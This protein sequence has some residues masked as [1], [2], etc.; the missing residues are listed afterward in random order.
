M[1]E[2]VRE[3]GPSA[4]ERGATVGRYTILAPLGMG[5]VGEVFAAYDPE[6]DRKVALKLLRAHGD[7]NDVRGQARLLREA[8]AMARLAHP[9]VVAVHDVGAFGARVFVAMEF[10]DGLSLKDWLAAAARPRAE[11]LSVFTSA[12]R[13]LAAAHAAGLVHRDFKPGNVMIGLDGSVRVMDFG[14]ARELS[15]KNAGPTAMDE[16]RALVAGDLNVTLTATGELMGTPLYMSPEQFRTAPTDA[17]TDQFSFCVALYQA[18][19]GDAPFGEAN[20]TAIMIEVL[21]GRVRA[22]PPKTGVPGWLRRVL[23]RG[24]S[25]APD[26]RWPSMDALIAALAHDPAR[27]RRRVALAVGALTLVALSSLTLVRAARRPALLCQGGPARL[28]SLWEPA[29]TTA[30]PRRDAVRAAFLASGAPAAGEVWDRVA[31]LLD[32]YDGS[33][34]T[35]YR[36]ACEATHVRGEQSAATLEL[37]MACLDERRT[38]MGALT[39]VLMTADHG[40]VSSA[41]D[42]VN[43]LPRLERCADVRQLRVPVE[44]PR[45]EETRRRVDQLRLGLAKA[46]ALNDTGKHVEARQLAR[47]QLVEARATSYRPI[48]A[49]ALSELASTFSG[50]NFT[51]E[52]LT[53]GQ[54]TVWT[55]LAASRDDLAA[56]SAVLVASNLNSYTTRV[57]EARYWE[58][59]AQALV[60]RLGE[61]HDRLRAW[62]LQD[63]AWRD[64]AA[65]RPR[66]ALETI[67]RAVALKERILPPQHPDIALSLNT[68]AEILVALGRTSE[69]LR[70]NERAYPM[71][72]QAYGAA[73]TEAA[74][75]LS[76][77]G[78][79]LVDLGRSAEALAPGRQALSGWEAQVGPEHAFLAFPLVVIGRALTALGR[80][81]DAVAPLERARRLREAGSVDPTLIAEACFALARALWDADV[82]HARARRLATQARDAYA[83]AKDTQDTATV[84]VWLAAHPRAT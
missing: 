27:A 20:L 78:E 28:A 83:N 69:A 63:E 70:I 48:V 11:I 13:G 59:A 4:L 19:Y 51:P 10:V 84:D 15:D 18:L 65:R 46:K 24:L 31:A 62:L 22:A 12:A 8:K 33:W 76:N 80:A 41:V 82:D 45:D 37:R 32:R 53:L 73:S 49:D 1:V 50:S 9:N 2:V 21:A 52:S 30:H 60:D 29:T 26:A 79:Y 39:D 66:E 14:L 38:A 23:V 43:A 42:S 61:G 36:D 57:D 47:A 6:L 68:E 75:T 34:L 5:G 54:E 74:F 40:V 55:A 25:V 17:R 72:V 81:A 67:Q 7:A 3:P 77:R 16:V 58:S 56:E 35:M 71:F 64:L 44:P